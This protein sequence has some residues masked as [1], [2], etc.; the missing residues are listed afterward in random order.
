MKRRLVSGEE[1]PVAMHQEQP[2]TAVFLYDRVYD[3]SPPSRAAMHT[4]RDTAN[5]TRLTKERQYGGC[6]CAALSIYNECLPPTT[7][8]PP[9][10][11]IH[12]CRIQQ[13]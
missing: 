2:R 8:K 13:F 10:I 5:P 3:L 9:C 11:L 1:P 4:G 7:S 6:V 12:L